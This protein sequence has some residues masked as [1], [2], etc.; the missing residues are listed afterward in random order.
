M[1][2]FSLI[3]LFENHFQRLLPTYSK[4]FR[5]FAVSAEPVKHVF[6][7]IM[8]MSWIKILNT[9][10]PR[11]EPRSAP[12]SIFSHELQKELTFALCFLS[13]ALYGLVTCPKATI[14]CLIVG[15]VK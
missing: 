9:T 3:R 13:F 5:A 10:G 8:K 2:E 12:D 1:P 14:P 15:G 7:N 4:V 6:F 11:I